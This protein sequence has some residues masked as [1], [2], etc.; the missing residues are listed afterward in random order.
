MYMR[1]KLKNEVLDLDRGLSD[2]TGIGRLCRRHVCHLRAVFGEV[3][4]AAALDSWIGV[5]V[6]Q[7][8]PRDDRG[9]MMQRVSPQFLR[10]LVEV[11]LP[12]EC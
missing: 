2:G 6:P 1:A 8:V 9:T 3:G 12:R 10:R 7:A 4:V 11:L 5:S